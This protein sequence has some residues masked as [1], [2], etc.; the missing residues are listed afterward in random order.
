M[1]HHHTQHLD[2]LCV[3]IDLGTSNTVCAVCDS[4]SKK[5]SVLECGDDPRNPNL[6]PSVVGYYD[7]GKRVV[8]SR[9]LDDIREYVKGN[10][11]YLTKRLLGRRFKEARVQDVVGNVS[12]AK[13]VGASERST[14][15]FQINASGH[16]KPDVVPEQVN[17]AIV[18]RVLKSVES[19]YEGFAVGGC[20]DIWKSPKTV[21]VV[22]VPANYDAAQRKAT[23][24]AV[25]IA[26]ISPERVHLL[27][28]PTAAAIAHRDT[29]NKSPPEHMTLLVYV[30]VSLLLSSSHIHTHTHSDTTLEE[31]QLM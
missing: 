7:G 24:H 5:V 11:F 31:V 4:R 3:G 20:S 2:F 10:T 27:N 17:A 23:R 6:L 8:G 21:V 30:C 14:V 18:S 28:E 19:Q 9:A 15:K 29:F 12:F 13:N 25:E 22:G 16:P 26:G 1:H